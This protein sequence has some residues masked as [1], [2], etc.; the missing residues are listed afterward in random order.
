MS[1]N[2]C[3]VC[4]PRLLAKLKSLCQTFNEGLLRGL[5]DQNDINNGQD[6]D[7]DD[8]DDDDGNDSDNTQSRSYYSSQEFREALVI[9]FHE[10]VMLLV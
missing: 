5:D 3:L 2:K 9:R 7:D 6:D 1:N 8:D 10:R 4:L